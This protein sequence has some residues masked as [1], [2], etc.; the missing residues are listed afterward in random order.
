MRRM[1]LGGRFARVTAFTAGVIISERIFGRRGADSAAPHAGD[2][3]RAEVGSIEA[4]LGRAGDVY[5]GLL[6]AKLLFGDRRFRPATPSAVRDP[7][8]A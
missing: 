1:G 2:V 8:S 6:A 7:T 4:D 5:L 3:L